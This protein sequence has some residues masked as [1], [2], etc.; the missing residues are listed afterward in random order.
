MSKGN[1][2]FKGKCLIKFMNVILKLDAR[3][4]KKRFDKSE[5]LG[6]LPRTKVRGLFRVSEPEIYLKAVVCTKFLD[7][8][9]PWE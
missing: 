4:S 5:T 8:K 3:I 7:R 2:I 6:I 1:L 9:I